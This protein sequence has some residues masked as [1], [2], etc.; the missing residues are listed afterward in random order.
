MT[1]LS[2]TIGEVAGIW[3]PEP[4]P[5]PE[6]LP[7]VSSCGLC[8]D[9][10]RRYRVEGTVEETAALLRAH[11]IARHGVVRPRGGRRPRP[12]TTV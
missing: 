9:D 11:R 10:E 7:V 8:P 4:Q 12:D 5:E 6:P 3:R 1:D 2:S